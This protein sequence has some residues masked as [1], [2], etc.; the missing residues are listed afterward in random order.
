MDLTRRQLLGAVGASTVGTAGCLVEQFLSAD[1]TVTCEDAQQTSAA[2]DPLADVTGKWPTS[3]ADAQNT[4]YVP[5]NLGRDTCP[6]VQWTYRITGEADIDQW[7]PTSPTVTNRTVYFPDAR[8]RLYAVDLVSGELDWEFQLPTSMRAPNKPTVYEDRLF[9]TG[10]DTVVAIDPTTPEI[11]WKRTTDPEETS[12]DVPFDRVHVLRAAPTVDGEKLVVV[13]ENGVVWCLDRRDGRTYWA[14]TAII[15]VQS[16]DKRADF[17]DSFTHSACVATGHVFV[18]RHDGTVFALD[19]ET[20]E[21]VWQ[22]TVPEEIDDAPVFAHDRLFIPTERNVYELDHTTGEVVWRLNGPE[23]VARGAPA[24][25]D[26]V[27]VVGRGETI[28]DLQLTAV[29]LADRTI[30]WETPTG[31]QNYSSPCHTDEVALAYT[32]DYAR[33][34]DLQTGEQLWK[35]QK[36]GDGRGTPVVVDDAV[37]VA[38]TDG[39]VF[40][41]A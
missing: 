14:F 7:V 28:E 3:H 12:S 15:D 6:S 4:G 30:R 36:E 16:D 41:L 9:I 10:G 11:L 39:Y 37:F 18:G 23:M 27:L 25:G 20:G 21:P 22:T 26:G 40:A 32:L 24:V 13:G 17:Q 33:C 8:Y 5:G 1:L 35:V 29:N 34:Y 2:D 31:M 38:D 19:L